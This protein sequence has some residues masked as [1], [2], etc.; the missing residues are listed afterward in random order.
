MNSTNNYHLSGI[1]LLVLEMRDGEPVIVDV[2]DLELEN[3]G[4]TRE[5]LIGKHPS[6]C[7]DTPDTEKDAI[8]RARKSAEQGKPAHFTSRIKRKD[9]TPYAISCMVTSRHDPKTDVLQ[10]HFL[11]TLIDY[12]DASLQKFGRS[13]IMARAEKMTGTGSWR[14]SKIYKELLVTENIHAIFNL[15]NNQDIQTQLFTKIP[16]SYARA[17]N[18]AVEECFE[19]ARAFDIKYQFFANDGT[20]YMGVVSGEAEQDETGSITAVVGVVRDL[21]AHAELQMEHGMFLRAA[22]I[23][24]LR[25]DDKNSMIRLSPEAARLLGE[26]DQTLDISSADWRARIHVDDQK[27]ASAEY[28]KALRTTGMTTRT[29]RIR[30]KD[31]AWKWFEIRSIAKFDSTD[32]PGIIYATIMDVDDRVNTQLELT[33]SEQR[34]RDVLSQSKEMIFELDANGTFSYISEMGPIIFGYTHE[35]FLTM[36]PFNLIKNPPISQADWLVARKNSG[37]VELEKL[38]YHKDGS[39]LH[40]NFCSKPIFDR[41]GEFTGFRGAARD[42]TDRKLADL[43]V[44]ENRQRLIEVVDAAQGWIFDLDA[45]GKFTF[46]SNAIENFTNLPSK[47]LIGQPTWV[48]AEY[49]KPDHDAWLESIRRSDR[50]VTREF[51]LNERSGD[52]GQWLE[53]HCVAR[54][55]EDGNCFGYRG[56]AFNITRKKR[57]EKQL[58]QAKKT[59]EAATEERAR[60]LSTMSHE[61]RTP[62][63]AVIGMTDL[64]L[65][66]KQPADQVKLTKSANMAGQ[67]MLSLVNDVLEHSKLEAGK[68]TLEEIPFDLAETVDNVY[69]I[70]AVTSQNKDIELSITLHQN[71]HAFYTSDPARIRQ[72]LIN[73]VGNALKFTDAGDVKIAISPTDTDRVR[74]EVTDTGIGISEQAQGKL[75]QDF[76]QAD[77]STTRKYGGTGLG[78]AISRRLVEAMNGEIGVFSTPNKGSTFWFELPI[79]QAQPPASQPDNADDEA[80][81][82]NIL[83]AE[84]NPANQLLIRTLLE[85]LGHTITIVENGQLAID[86]ASSQVFDLV[87]MDM[88]MP[89]MDGY[90]AAKALRNLGNQVPIIALTAHVTGDEEHKFKAAGMND[91]LSKPYHMT[92]LVKRISYWGAIGQQQVQNETNR[93]LTRP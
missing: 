52:G 36:S 64:L 54:F 11:S 49:L 16:K 3:N 34:F 28:D 2:N 12:D 82:F 69:D 61:I 46:T 24:A 40:V 48:L 62:L 17:I 19:T 45:E 65:D 55:D 78:L 70:F 7:F 38:L 37:P 76:V 53:V 9:G 57:A 86:A 66:C 32:Q 80:S 47:E 15:D 23:G 91:W 85:K 79:Q 18:A 29:Y 13:D 88:Q 26:D 8:L 83:V 63:N 20:Q 51:R 4:F 35:E 25:V 81:C 60:F 93:H 74:F 5:E 59:A 84:D 41:H 33:A 75:F 71:L 27:N 31:G 50:G 1:A 72:V 14:Y 44:E 6:D 67:H 89:V 39:P 77:A 43:A 42:I 22:K 90:T 10:Y 68:V 56:V 87:F 21:T 30:C 58:I 92:E 73:L